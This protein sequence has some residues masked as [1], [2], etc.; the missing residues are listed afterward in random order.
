MK[1]ENIFNTNPLLVT[2]VIIYQMSQSLKSGQLITVCVD[3]LNYTQDGFATGGMQDGGILFF[4]TIDLTSYPSW[5]DFKGQ[6]TLAKTGDL[7]TVCSFV[8]R[9]G[10]INTDPTWF[11]YDVYEILID[12]KL[13]QAFKQNLFPF[14][15]D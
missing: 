8:G 10:K 13:R 11:C 3:G 14:K 6:S 12:G 4:E 9:P 2:Y 15:V 5:N 1:I 7:A